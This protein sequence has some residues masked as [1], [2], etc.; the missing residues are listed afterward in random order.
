MICAGLGVYFMQH[1]NSDYTNECRQFAKNNHEVFDPNL[2]RINTISKTI[3]HIDSLFELNPTEKS[4]DSFRYIQVA[5]NVVKNKF[6][7]GNA[8]YEWRENWIIFVLGKYVWNHFNSIV[9]PEKVIRHCSAMCSQQTMVFTNIMRAK[10]YHYR[11]VYILDTTSTI[12]HFTCEIWLD[13]QW[14]YFDVNAEPNWSKLKGKPNISMEMLQDGHKLSKIYDS[15][16]INIQN[17]VNKETKIEYSSTDQE[18][19]VKMIWV[20]KVTKFLSWFGLI[21]LGV[22]GILNS[23]YQ[24]IQKGK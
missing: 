19:G 2:S 9:A 3:A 13:N 1:R 14:H 5:K 20:Q 10:G 23:V 15:S 22:V 11:Y 21:A 18:V 17:L 7:H 24:I 8:S 16:Y 12:G 6:Y 4:F